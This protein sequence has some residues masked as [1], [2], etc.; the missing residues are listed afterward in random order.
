VGVGVVGGEVGGF[1]LVEHG[2]A[3]GGDAGL[4]DV[5]QGEDVVDGDFVRGEGGRYR[6]EAQDHSSDGVVSSEIHRGP[7]ITTA[8]GEEAGMERRESL[9]PA[10]PR[11][12][13]AGARLDMRRGAPPPARGL[14][15]TKPN[16]S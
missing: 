13:H 12:T 16:S 6:G 14:V 7:A 1:D 11:F 2:V 10:V 4:G 5:L 3:G 8:R 9:G 15:L